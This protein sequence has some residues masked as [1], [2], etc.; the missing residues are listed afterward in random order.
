MQRLKSHIVFKIVTITVV[1]ALLTP[2][3]L[4]F[5]HIFNHHEHEACKGEYKVHLH[6][7]DV[8]CS[9]Q[10]FK[11]TKTFTIP[12]F[13]VNF[14]SPIHNHEISSIQYSFLSDT[15]KLQFKLRGPPY[16]I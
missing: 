16:L 5:V 15:C 8:D 12:E 14:F 11:L 7:L 6:T 9:Y 1:L 10:K 2:I 4:K 13:S 3:T